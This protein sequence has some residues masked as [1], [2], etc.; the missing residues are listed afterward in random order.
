MSAKKC[1][2]LFR[3]ADAYIFLARAKTRR[4]VSSYRRSTSKDGFIS[5]QKQDKSTELTSH[6]TQV[7]IVKTA[8]SFA[9][10]FDIF[11]RRLLRASCVLYGILSIL[12]FDTFF[13]NSL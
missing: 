8:F 2:G 3:Q 1:H 13:I 12:A 11:L 9:Y 4:L 6:S 7:V 10:I 5:K